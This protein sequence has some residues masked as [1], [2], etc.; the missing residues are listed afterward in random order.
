[1]VPYNKLTPISQYIDTT[2]VCFLLTLHVQSEVRCGGG[3]A[4]SAPVVTLIQ[5][6]GGATIWSLISFHGRTK[7][8]ENSHLFFYSQAWK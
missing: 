8:I 1:M 5:A 4:G 2:E 3:Q 7:L 6:A